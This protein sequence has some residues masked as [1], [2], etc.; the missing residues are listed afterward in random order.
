MI[1]KGEIKFRRDKKNKWYYARYKDDD[2]MCQMTF[3]EEYRSVLGATFFR[4]DV[5][6]FVGKSARQ[7]TAYNYGNA[8]MS[9]AERRS[10]I[11]GTGKPT[12]LIWATK[13]LSEFEKFILD[14]RGHRRDNEGIV[15][16]ILGEDERRMKVCE[17][18]LRKRG[19]IENKYNTNIMYPIEEPE[20]YLYK[21]I[22]NNSRKRVRL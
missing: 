8:D 17:R 12:Y 6:L 9:Y 15:I 10:K 14:E 2:R 1:Y 19:Y 16:T 20:Y 4:Y 21:V 22:K 5:S 13:V 3:K 18:Y 11:T 7:C